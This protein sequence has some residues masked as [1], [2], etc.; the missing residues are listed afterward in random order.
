M[1]Q[2]T[3]SSADDLL[4][5]Q[6]NSRIVPSEVQ[7]LE[8]QQ[9]SRSSSLQDSLSELQ[10]LSNGLRSMTAPSLVSSSE[11]S[12]SSSDRLGQYSS[13]ENESSLDHM[14]SAESS[15]RPSIVT[16]YA[17]PSVPSVES[18][19]RASVSDDTPSDVILASPS[20]SSSK[21]IHKNNDGEG[22][23]VQLSSSFS[24]GSSSSSL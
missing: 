2:Q 20:S 3:S 14:S 7:Q 10:S 21:R 17:D 18:K 4:A 16:Y 15:Y 12:S 11:S 22:R 5:E 13:S 24:M 6:L 1:Q 8:Q 23:S 19:M 9:P